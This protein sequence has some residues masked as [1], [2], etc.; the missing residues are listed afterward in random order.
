MSGRLDV[1]TVLAPRSG[2]WAEYL[3]LL[4]VQRK[5]AEKFRHRQIIVTDADLPQFET[6]RVK[7]ADSLMHAIIEGQIAYLE[8]WS[9]DHPVVLT[10]ADCLIARN[11]HEVFDG[12][13]DLGLNNRENDVS[14][15]NNGAMYVGPGCK[16]EVLA[17]FQHALELCKEHW[18]GDQEAI[19]QA[20]APVPKPVMFPVVE[21]RGGF[22]IA[23]LPMNVYGAAPKTADFRM[24][25][26]PFIVHFKGVEPKRWM[27][28]YAE[29]FVLV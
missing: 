26:N 29:R 15:I 24:N 23:F 27:A 3:P 20:A 18:G 28:G 13:F 4:E 16:A 10:D 7:L 8:A 1:V 19:S 5:T 25:R 6:M 2:R 9:G 12:S 22:R 11:L 17:F 14:P 21:D